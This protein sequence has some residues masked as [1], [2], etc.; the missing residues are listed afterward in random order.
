M[1]HHAIGRWAAAAAA[2]ALAVVGQSGTALAATA[3]AT[4]NTPPSQP[5]L[6][7]LSTGSK[8]CAAGADLPYVSSRPQLRAVLR[9]PDATGAVSV[10]L[11][12]EFEASW[13]AADDTLQTRT[14]TPSYS[15]SSGSSFTWTTPSDLP[16]DTVISWR[17]RATDGTDW[18]PWSS[19]DGQG[20]CEFIY[21]DTSPDK[22]AVSSAD[23][24]DDDTWHDGVGVYGG[25]TFDSPSD[26]VVAYVYSFTG[27]PQET[28]QAPAPGAPVT[29][30]W[31]PERDAPYNL[32]VQ[33][34]DRSGRLSAST[35]YGFRVTDGRTPVAYWKLADAAGS[36]EASDSAGSRP[37]TAG[38]GVTF[39]ASG[40]SRTAVTSAA[41]FDGSADA[42]AT[43]GEPVL[44]TAGTFVVSAWARPASAGQDLTAVSQG[45]VTL[46]LG[47]GAWTFALG[48]VRVSGGSPSAGEWTHLVGVY[49]AELKTARLYVNGTSVGTAEASP[50]ASGGDLLIGRDADGNNWNG[51]L[52]DVRVWNRV[53]VSTEA[54]ALA[55]RAP[56]R[57]GYWQL[58]TASDGASPELGGGPQ[59]TLAGDASIRTTPESSCDVLED[60]DCVPPSDPIVGT[61]DLLL[62]G[63]GDYASTADPVVDTDDSFTVTALV[64]LDDPDATR[65]M[66]VLA[67][68]GEHTN[69]FVVR[70]AAATHSWELA[71]SHADSSDAEVTAVRTYANPGDTTGVQALAVVYD[72]SADQIR[73]YVDRQLAATAQV[74]LASSDTWHATGGLQVGRAL[75]ADGWGE[76]FDGRIDEVRA[77]AGVLSTTAIVQVGSGVELPDM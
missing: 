22:P 32:S 42:Y 1:A 8:S 75:T 2:A 49:D 73:L 7:E 19:D 67:A 25:F 70:Y 31:M 38:G 40:P 11:K 65:D 17:V 62:D 14:Y 41:G 24:P 72:D 58:N 59:L 36:A 15:L 63:D 39:G 23:Y 51:L 10:S 3:T 29:I 9:D 13:T 76:Y 69:A 44:D 56:E 61:G 77:Y 50:A 28:V 54:T 71:M 45:D 16:A 20:R 60:P 74:S 46:G 66:A 64:R 53:V 68:P 34:V 57:Q 37:A 48:G 55:A 33:S 6:S 52:A 4:A 26:D 12:A 47:D 43:P 27:G 30:R 5:L 18:S 35:T 21:D